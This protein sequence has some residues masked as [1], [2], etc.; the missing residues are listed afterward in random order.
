MR[1]TSRQ[2][3]AVQLIDAALLT[4]SRSQDPVDVAFRHSL[5]Y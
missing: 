4:T 1:T 5:A 3:R 2:R